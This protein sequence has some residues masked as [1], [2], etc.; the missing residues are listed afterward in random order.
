MTDQAPDNTPDSEKSVISEITSR[1]AKVAS[2][3]TLAEINFVD[4]RFSFQYVESDIKDKIRM[5]FKDTNVIVDNEQIT[6]NLYFIFIAP[7]PFETDNSKQVDIFAQVQ[8]IYQIDNLNDL[9]EDDIILFGKVNGIYNAWPYLREYVRSSVTRLGL[10][11]FD[12]PLLN[13]GMA[14]GFA[15]ILPEN[16]NKPDP[17]NDD[18]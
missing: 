5:G 6:S 17:N 11:S 8:L 15:G 12:L 1:S 18:N 9:S 2:N 3:A 13:I 10:P 7:S 16:S 14:V 4:C